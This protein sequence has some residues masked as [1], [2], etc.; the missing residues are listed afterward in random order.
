MTQILNETHL[1]ATEQ[2]K[3]GVFFGKI[4]RIRCLPL[5]VVDWLQS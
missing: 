5:P 4:G 3:G 1:S 2:D